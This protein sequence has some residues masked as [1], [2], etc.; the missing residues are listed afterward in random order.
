MRDLNSKH[1]D[2]R[3]LEI[4][5]ANII[6]ADLKHIVICIDEVTI[7]LCILINAN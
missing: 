5:L 1:H 7:T 2:N 4:L 6:S 3:C